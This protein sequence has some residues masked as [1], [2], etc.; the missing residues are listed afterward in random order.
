MTQEATPADP[1]KLASGGL[2]EGT[3]A[4]TNATKKKD[5]YDKQ[6]GRITR[7]LSQVYKVEITRGFAK[8]EIKNFAKPCVSVKTAAP[9]P[10]MQSFLSAP[11][12]LGLPAAAVLRLL[13]ATA[14]AAVR[15][16]AAA[17]RCMKMVAMTR[18]T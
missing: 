12:A 6:D 9:T 16:S 13:P 15:L 5:S 17:A 14:A 18:F 8:G 4:M 10:S 7:V 11:G 3:L 2:P 1:A